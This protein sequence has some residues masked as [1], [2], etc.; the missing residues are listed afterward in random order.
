MTRLAVKE[1]TL[2]WRDDFPILNKPTSSG[3][4]LAYLDNGATTQKPTQVLNALRH[5]YE[6]DN[7]N[8]HRGVYELS[9]RAT[10]AYES[11]RRE[12]ADFIG[13]KRSDEIVFVRGATE[14]INL[15][16]S[17]YLREHCK[18]KDEI[19]LSVMEHHANIVPWQALAKEKDLLIRVVPIDAQGELDMTVFHSFLSKK[20][21]MVA[22][23][24]ISNVLGT[25]NPVKDIVAAS[26][27]VGAKVLIDGAQATAH[28]PVD[29]HDLGVDF[30]TFSGHKTFG[31]TGIGVL[32]VPYDLLLS[33][34]PYQTG[35]SM[36]ERVSFERSTYALPPLRFEAGTPNISGAIAMAVACRYVLDVGYTKIQSHEADML[37]KMEDIFST[38]PKVT[39]FGHSPGKI[40]MVSFVYEGVHAHDIATI[41]DSEG[42]A[43]RAGHHCCMPL[44][45]DLGVA[46]TTRVSLALYNDAQDMEALA[47]GLHMVEKTF[48]G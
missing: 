30:Y 47:R 29:V 17:A 36:I 37:T 43:V 45:E 24:H 33:M 11:A 32:Y 14:A 23:T 34:S 44:M 16:A 38:Y 31:P 6:F 2:R 19:I 3:K 25:V 8:V 40:G 26:H 41:M 21:K 1:S 7:A 4:Q 12:I 10:L 5:Y 20:T 13:A 18:P 35:G 48:Y 15:V 42:V 28:M 9:A 27:N 46:A 22:L 39:S